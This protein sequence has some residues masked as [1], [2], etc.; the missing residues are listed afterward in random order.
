MV[1]LTI[2]LLGLLV[3]SDT[4]TA[5][6]LDRRRLQVSF[7]GRRRRHVVST[8]LLTNAVQCMATAHESFLSESWGEEASLPDSLFQTAFFL[9]YRRRH[10]RSIHFAYCRD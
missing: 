1:K 4:T 7:C 6:R 10:G 5:M 8:T 9:S 2:A 3:L